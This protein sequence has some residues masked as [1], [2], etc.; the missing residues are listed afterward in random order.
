M[1]PAHID[2]LLSNVDEVLRL[3]EIHEQ[4]TGTGRGRRYDTEILNKSGVVLLVACWEA[5][6]EDLATSAF[7]M[8]ITLAADHTAFPTKVLTLASRD[9]RSAP[10][11][12]RVWDLAGVGWQTVLQNHRAAILKRFAG[13]LNTP[14]PEQVDALFEDLVGVTRLSNGWRWHRTTAD[15][16]RRRLTALV[17]L[18]GDIAH[19]VTTSRP[20]NK[21][22]VVLA[23][24][25]VRRLAAVSSNRVREHV[26]AR[27]NRYP[28]NAVQYG[29]A[30]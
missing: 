2:N 5:Y 21:R 23:A 27:V 20:V 17:E 15:S 6:V 7:N 11:E 29:G 1:P 4:I 10:D 25:F 12:R 14:K 24:E 30:A 9:L 19:R 26:H 13:S 16:A 3:V 18:R 8:M 22:H 28:W